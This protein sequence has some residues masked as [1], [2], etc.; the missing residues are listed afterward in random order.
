MVVKVCK[1]GFLELAPSVD[2]ASLEELGPSNPGLKLVQPSV[3]RVV[4]AVAAAKL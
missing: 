1:K 3:L 4:G 2:K